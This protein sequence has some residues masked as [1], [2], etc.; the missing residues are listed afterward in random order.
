MILYKNRLIIGGI[1]KI[2]GGIFSFI[3]KILKF[4]NLQLS[5]LVVLVGVVLFFAGVF[6]NNAILEMIFFI[7]LIASIF[8]GVIATVKSI[9]FP[10]K[11]E[12]KKRAKVKIIKTEEKEQGKDD[13]K[14][15]EHEEV[16]Q[17]NPPYVEKVL[18]KPRYYR[19]KQNPD[20]VMAEYSDR[21]ELYQK[22][23]NGLIKL[24]TDYKENLR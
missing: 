21:F 12:E 7:V 16:N 13:I 20:Y 11:R 17:T 22:T 4:F 8:W 3:Y 1:K 6:E 5:L 9:L 10:N 19:V 2:L 15:L 18:D 23:S 24:R 14:A